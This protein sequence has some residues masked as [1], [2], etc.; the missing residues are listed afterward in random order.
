M[1]VYQCVIRLSRHWNGT[2]TS[3]LFGAIVKTRRH[4]HKEVEEFRHDFEIQPFES[5]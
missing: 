2:G 5:E 1:S 3:K 4:Y